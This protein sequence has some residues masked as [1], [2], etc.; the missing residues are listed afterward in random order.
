M[1][2]LCQPTDQG[3]STFLLIKILI[4]TTI[5]TTKTKGSIQE[6]IRDLMEEAD[7]DSMVEVK[8]V[9][10]LTGEA[11]DLMAE[12]KVSMEVDKALMVVGRASILTKTK[13]LDVRLD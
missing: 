11:K 12:D 5:T 1:G 13:A 8:E 10:A 3:Y 6:E 9:K 4:L 7:K 2:G